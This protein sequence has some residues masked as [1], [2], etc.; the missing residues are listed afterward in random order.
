MLRAKIYQN[1]SGQRA[2]QLNGVCANLLNS[3]LG[4]GEIGRL[5]EPLQES[6]HL[7]T[8]QTEIPL[9]YRG[10]GLLALFTQQGGKLKL[11]CHLLQHGLYIKSL[12]V[13]WQDIYESVDMLRHH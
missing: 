9:K 3:H 6:E 5:W 10:P 7:Q 12:R 4:R 13:S 8:H 2:G 11:T 1:N